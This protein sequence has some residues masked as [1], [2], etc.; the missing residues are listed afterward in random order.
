M[1]FYPLNVEGTGF[2][3]FL[4]ET[5]SAT[6]TALFDGLT[7]EEARGTDFLENLDPLFRK[8]NERDDSDPQGGQGT[9]QQSRSLV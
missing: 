4:E 6:V 3:P 1:E 8:T 5:K 2:L 9:N 7:D